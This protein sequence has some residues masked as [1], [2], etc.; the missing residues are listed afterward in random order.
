MNP[1]INVFRQPMI[2]S[3][4]ILMGFLL[5]FLASWATTDDNQ[6]AIQSLADWVVAL[7]LLS[8]LVL[9][10]YVLF[11]LLNNRY[12]VQQAVTYYQHI[13]RFYMLSI[14]LAF[15]GLSISLFL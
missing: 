7:T 9:M 3:L 11:K 2:T 15:A 14:C 12:D 8:S 1:D 6:P 4:G 10:I 5:N 13:F